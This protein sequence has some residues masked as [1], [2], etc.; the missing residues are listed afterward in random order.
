MAALL[1]QFDEREVSG[2]LVSDTIRLYNHEIKKELIIPVPKQY[3]I[4]KI[5]SLN[6]IGGYYIYFLEGMPQY[7]LEEYGKPE[8]CSFGMYKSRHPLKDDVIYIDTTG[9]KKE[10]FRKIQFPNLRKNAIDNINTGSFWLNCIAFSKLTKK[11]TLTGEKIIINSKELDQK[12]N[13]RLLKPHEFVYLILREEKQISAFERDILKAK[14]EEV[15]QKPM[16]GVLIVIKS[17]INSYLDNWPIVMQ[18]NLSPTEYS[19]V[20]MG[21]LNSLDLNQLQYQ[22][23]NEDEETGVKQYLITYDRKNSK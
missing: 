12:N 16:K 2:N 20:C 10:D 13:S 3:K 19:L 1:I 23:Y 9:F 21:G 11:L 15:N 18:D 8:V 4:K 17:V 22:F 5:C 6:G 14:Y 7:I